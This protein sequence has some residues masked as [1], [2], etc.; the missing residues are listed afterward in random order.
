MEAISKELVELFIANCANSTVNRKWICYIK[1]FHFRTKP[2]QN[3]LTAIFYKDLFTVL[4]SSCHT[5][6][7]TLFFIPNY[8][9][10]IQN[11]LQK[12]LR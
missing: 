7:V 6:K 4:S 1:H 2:A 10:P 5:N 3:N 9:I 12:F 11:A 8:I